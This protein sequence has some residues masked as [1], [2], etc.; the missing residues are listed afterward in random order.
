MKKQQPSRR[1]RGE[2]CGARRERGTLLASGQNFFI[3]AGR[4]P[5][6][7]VYFAAS[8]TREQSQSRNRRRYHRRSVHRLSFL[9][10]ATA[11]HFRA[12]TLAPRPSELPAHRNQGW[13]SWSAHWAI[14]P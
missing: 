10:R 7:L 11:G 14:R 8:R 12:R 4:G 5:V 1:R 3:P 6:E 2:C 9:S 13:R